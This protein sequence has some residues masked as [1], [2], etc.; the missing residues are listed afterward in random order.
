MKVRSTLP[1]ASCSFLLT[2]FWAVQEVDGLGGHWWG[3]ALQDDGAGSN[4]A[5]AGTSTA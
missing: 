5:G 1:E 2:N 4:D 3:D